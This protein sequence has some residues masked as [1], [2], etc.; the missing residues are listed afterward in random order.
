MSALNSWGKNHGL[1]FIKTGGSNKVNGQLTY[2]TVACDRGGQEKASRA[3]IRQ[4]STSKTK[5]PWSG[6]AKALARNNRRWTFEVK[7]ADHNHRTSSDRAALTTHQVHRGLTDVMRTEVSALSR[8]AGIQ[9]RDINSSLREKY[10]DEVFTIR[11]INNYRDRE[12]RINLEGTVPGTAS[13]TARYD[14]PQAIYQRYTAARSVWYAAQPRGS[15]RTNQ[16]YRRAKGLPLRYDK[17][18]YVWSL[19][20][21]QMD[22]HCTTS[23]GSREWT[24]EEMMAYL[25]WSKAEDQRIDALV[26]A[27]MSGNPFASRRRGTRA[28]WD[29]VERDMEEQSALYTVRK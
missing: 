8:T 29:M 5:C 20:Y 18:S 6:V 19:D 2:V 23:T 10:P 27:D 16:E 24:K 7:N 12:K 21:I 3:T 11:D 4:T 28:I 9:P 17:R 25:D 15:I 14:S 22:K 1:G 13:G 26:A